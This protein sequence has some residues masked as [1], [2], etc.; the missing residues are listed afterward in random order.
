MDLGILRKG[1]FILNIEM[2]SRAEYSQAL[3][4]KYEPKGSILCEVD[5]ACGIISALRR[6]HN[7]LSWHVYI[8]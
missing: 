4:R 7:S 2:T 1:V 6:L 8:P 5:Y 3:F